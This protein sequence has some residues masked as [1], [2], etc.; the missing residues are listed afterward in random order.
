L[1]KDV[2]HLSS[3]SFES[4]LRILLLVSDGEL[5][6]LLDHVAGQ[7]D[8]ESDGKDT[9]ATFQSPTY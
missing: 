7:Q 2:D 1:A 5:E 9:Q 4:T 6:M 3:A 8:V